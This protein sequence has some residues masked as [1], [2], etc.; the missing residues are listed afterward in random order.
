MLVLSLY[1]TRQCA[2]HFFNVLFVFSDHGVSLELNGA[3]HVVVGRHDMLER[4]TAANKGKT[5]GGQRVVAGKQ[6]I[7]LFR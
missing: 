5:I 4:M 7:I 3:E 6:K 1:S 2:L